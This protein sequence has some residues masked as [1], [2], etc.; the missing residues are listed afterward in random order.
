[1]HHFHKIYQIKPPDVNSSV[2]IENW[3]EGEKD[4]GSGDAH[5]K[6]GKGEVRNIFKGLKC[7]KMRV[8]CAENFHFYAETVE[9]RL[10]YH[11][12]IEEGS[13]GDDFF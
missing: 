5:Q 11:T 9:F 8:Q 13:R 4:K 10:F 2:N 3:G 6:L 7:K 12:I 1:M